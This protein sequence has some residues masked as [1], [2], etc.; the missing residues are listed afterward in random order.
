MQ[1]PEDPKG[2]KRGHRTLNDHPSSEQNNAPV[3]YFVDFLDG[4]WPASRL[5]HVVHR[6]VDPAVRPHHNK[7][8]Y[9]ALWKDS[10]ASHEWTGS[11]FSIESFSEKRPGA[12]LFDQSCLSLLEFGS[13]PTR[14]STLVGTESH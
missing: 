3:V 6:T 2:F 5:V 4:T 14:T 9:S 7:A 8:E 11:S 10:T 1:T 12:V 13:V